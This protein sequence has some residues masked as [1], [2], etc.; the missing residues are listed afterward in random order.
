MD[1]R[2]HSL[3]MGYKTLTGKIMKHGNHQVLFVPE[4]GRVVYQDEYIQNGF[5]ITDANRQE[6][7]AMIKAGYENS[8]LLLRFYEL[9]D[10]EEE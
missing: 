8:R 4:L 2:C 9:N 1:L 10:G 6:Q 3:M 7:H 5:H